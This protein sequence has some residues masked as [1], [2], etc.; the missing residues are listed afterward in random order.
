[1]SDSGPI[2]T[3]GGRRI[4][5]LLAAYAA[6]TLTEP[7][8]ALVAA[9]LQMTADD[10]AYAAPM[11]NGRRGALQLSDVDQ[12]N[13]LMPLA[14]RTYVSR[15][16]ASLKWR[17][18]LPG[19]KECR[20]AR[21]ARGDVSFL[22]CRPGSALPAHTHQ[23]LEAVLVLQGGFSDATGHYVRGD[24]AVSDD[25]TDHRPVADRTIEC[26]VFSVLEAPVKLTGPIGRVIQRLYDRCSAYVRLWP[27]PS[28]LSRTASGRSTAKWY[29]ERAA[30][31]ARL[32][33]QAISA[34]AAESFR[35]L[36][37]QWL[38]IAEIA[39]LIEKKRGR[40]PL[41]GTSHDWSPK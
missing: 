28:R 39:N 37:Q 27:T 9:H 12:L 23:G 13:A 41:D 3:D 36:E 8:T 6:G 34:E 5:A 32:A 1:M 26:I 29:R 35:Y 15:H 40:S 11:Q 30:I 22:R 33:E 31:C 16:L 19:I 18:I 20:I 25:T 17:T 10:R 7:F 21:N 2:R 24:I 14:L 38:V 4:D